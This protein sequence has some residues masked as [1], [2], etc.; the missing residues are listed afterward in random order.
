MAIKVKICGLTTPAAVTAAVEGGA[1]YIG[2]VI[3]PPSPRAITTDKAAALKALLPKSV[4][5]VAVCVDPSDPLLTEITE[6]IAPDYLQLHGAETP[7]RVAEIKRRFSTP[8]IKGLGIRTSADLEA[9]LA[10]AD[11]ADM[12]LLDARSDSPEMPGGTGHS[13]DWTLLA[14]HTFPLPWFLSGGLNE[15][16]LAAALRTTGT[17]LIDVS[18]GVES[19]RGVKDLNKI[20]SFLKLAHSLETL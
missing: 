8:I 7:E 15:A 5:S 6:T 10:F 12:L 3:H 11:C 1:D 18:S 13:F 9:A 2:F 14:G 20:R 19:S 17:S 16:N 4:K